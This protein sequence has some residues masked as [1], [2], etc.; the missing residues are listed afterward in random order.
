MRSGRG[1]R[2]SA[3]RSQPVP[4]TRDEESRDGAA[5]GPLVSG[6]HPGGHGKRLHL[7]VAGPLESK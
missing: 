6:R 4:R 3:A 5:A 1:F 2:E 7:L